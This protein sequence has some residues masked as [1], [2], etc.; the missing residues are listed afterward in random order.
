MIVDIEES[1]KRFEEKFRSG[2]FRLE[3]STNTEVDYSREKEERD[4]EAVERFAKSPV[5]GE[6]F[7]RRS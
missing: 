2:F 1:T 6:L 7:G 3:R 5:F 4:V